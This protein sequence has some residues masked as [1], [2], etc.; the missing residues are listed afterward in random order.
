MMST[1]KFAAVIATVFVS[2]MLVG[3]SVAK[4]PV[5]ELVP[6]TLDPPT[7]DVCVL[8]NLERLQHVRAAGVFSPFVWL[9]HFQ[10]RWNR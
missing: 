8:N 9:E 3:H 7:A 10:V 2:G 4:Q 1:R 6:A 5:V